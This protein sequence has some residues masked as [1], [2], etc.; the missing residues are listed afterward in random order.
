MENSADNSNNQERLKRALLALQKMQL[1]LDAVKNKAS[2]AIAI[3]GMGCRYPGAVNTPERLWELLVDEIDAIIEVP[4]ERWPID[5]YYDADPNVAGKMYTRYGG[6]IDSVYEFDAAF[7]NIAPREAIN[8]DPQQRLLLEVAWEALEHAVIAPESLKGSQTGVFIGVSS[9]EYGQLLMNRAPET[10]DSYVG[11]GNAHSVAAGRLSY[12]LDLKGPSIAIDTACSSSLVAIHTACQNLRLGDCDMA[13]SGGVNLLLTPSVTLNHSRARMLAADGRCKAFDAAADGFIRSD[14]CGLLILKRLS[15]AKAA[16]DNIFAVI[17]GSAVNQ[18]GKTSGL[19]V[20]NGPSQKAVINKALGNAGVKA[21]DISYIETHGTG[22]SLGDPIE[23]G[24]L[25][26]VFGD[27]KEKQQPLHIGSIKTNIGHAEAAAGA[28]GVMKVV[29]SL[30]HQKIPR[31]L[32][33]KTPN[34]LINGSMFPGEIP[35]TTVPWLKKQK[36]RYAGVSSFGFGGTNAHLILSD[37][38]ELT[39]GEPENRAH[40]VLTLSAKSE[41]ALKIQCDRYQRFLSEYPDLNISDLCYSANTGRSHLNYRSAWVV[42]SID[43]LTLQLANVE[44]SANPTT[45]NPGIVFLFTGQGSQY[46]GMGRDLY[47][48]EAVFRNV[49][50]RCQNILQIEFNIDLLAVLY[51]KDATSVKIH[52]TAYAQ[53]AIFAIQFALAELWRSWG[54]EPD[55]VMGHSVGEYAAAAVA[56]VFTLED[57]LRLIAERG[58]LMQALPQNGSMLAVAAEEVS[59]KN[60]LAAYQHQVVIAAF[61]GSDNLVLSG[62]KEALININSELE[63]SDIKTNWLTVSHAFHS[64]LMQPMQLEFESY[65]AKIKYKAPTINYMSCLTGTWEDEMLCSASYWTKH[66]I[67]PVRFVESMAVLKRDD[68]SAFVELG[69]KPILLGM[70]ELAVDALALPSLRSQQNALAQMLRSLAALYQYGCRVSWSEIYPACR[71]QKVVLPGYPFQRQRYQIKATMPSCQKSESAANWYEVNWQPEEIPCPNVDSGHTW[72]IFADDQSLAPQLIEQ[73]QAEG[74]SWHCVYVADS[75]QALDAQSSTINPV[76]EQ[77]YRSLLDA[78]SLPDKVLYLWG[79]NSLASNSMSLNDLRTATDTRIL[80]ALYL[81]RALAARVEPAKLWLVTANTQVVMEK[82]NVAGLSSAPLWGLGKTLA[83]EYPDVWGGMIDLSDFEKDEA[84]ILLSVIRSHQDEDWCAI[85]GDHYFVPRLKVLDKPKTVELSITENASYLIT[86]GLGGLGL[87]LATWLVEK[88]AKHLVL[89]SRSGISN[90]AMAA[91]VEKLEQAGTTVLTLS[92]DVSKETEIAHLFNT[93]SAQCPPLHGIIHAA[94]LPGFCL[95]S[96]LTGEQFNT[97]FSAKVYGTWLLSQHSEQSPL[98]FFVCCSSMVS[99]W[100][101]KGQAHYVAANQFLDSLVDYRRQRGLP[102]LSVNWGPMT[103]GGMLPTESIDELVKI[104]VSTLPMA[105]AAII[106][107]QLLQANIAQAVIADI[108]WDLYKNIYQI[109]KSKPLFKLIDTSGK[110]EITTTQSISSILIVLQE[111]PSSEQLSILTSHVSRVLSQVLGMA[112]K[113]NMAPREGFFDL[114][115][116]SLTAMELKNRLQVDLELSLSASLAFDYATVETLAVYLLGRL[117]EV[118]AKVEL[119]ATDKL[120]N[121]KSIKSEETITHIQQ[122]SEQEAEA[123]LISRLQGLEE[124]DD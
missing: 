114:G 33:Y 116:D 70:A 123:L 115:M 4:S 8:M 108:N 30:Q 14:G 46:L 100:G 58:R 24:A 45:K 25:T 34:H 98:D 104:G 6:F 26:E 49:L 61:N 57:G 39:P 99:V 67:Q 15:D 107:E 2:E 71:S 83:L 63:K 5:D 72:L 12:F 53:P 52:Q 10:I 77:D 78:I 47:Q 48:S 13:I 18:D 42:D 21:E 84:K 60:I 66:I 93:I 91:A 11:S 89:C 43:D 101:A 121:E 55:T 105:D 27:A 16:G 3:V 97:Q 80:S 17:H 19:T 1:K 28:A 9:T 109:N 122:L 35:L 59:I 29:L 56:G 120:Q 92:V 90:D 69:G 124:D 94:G 37:Y 41:E 40:H 44:I 31:H 51:P 74:D 38:S 32:H 54:I 23:I 119:T 110:V 65:A 68:F 81:S 73:L 62:N 82:D 111:A 96:E 36:P 79:L 22:T 88:G 86:G 95:A 103:N 76:S 106:L 113:N 64:P 75:Y 85:R 20:P 117:N 87:V 7:F 112:G 118:T 102:A 50:D